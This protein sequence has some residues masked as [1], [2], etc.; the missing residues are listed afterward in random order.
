MMA[1]VIEVPWEYVR[2]GQGVIP[3]GRSYHQTEDDLTLFVD[4]YWQDLRNAAA[5][6]GMDIEDDS[7]EPHLHF[8]EFSR[9]CLDK[10]KW[11]SVGN[12]LLVKIK[13]GS[14]GIR[15]QS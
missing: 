2:S 10:K 4:R 9:P 6:A 8:K 11:V 3:A 5:N 15:E 7:F 13:V 14:N 12:V 1:N